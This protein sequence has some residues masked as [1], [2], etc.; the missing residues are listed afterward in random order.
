LAADSLS[1]LSKGH[2]AQRRSL[3][4]SLRKFKRPWR[5]TQERG[6]EGIDGISSGCEVLALTGTSLDPAGNAF[7]WGSF[8]NEAP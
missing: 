4:Q 8:F 6:L 7:F 1:D 3:S 2:S 5:Q